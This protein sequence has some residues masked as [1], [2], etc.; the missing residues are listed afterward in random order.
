[1]LF[2]LFTGYILPISYF[3]GMKRTIAF[4]FA[5]LFTM[6]SC[7][8]TATKK[9]D[10]PKPGT[11]VAAESE[12]V[13]EDTLNHSIFAVQVIADSNVKSGVYM[14]KAAFGLNKS[15][16]LF[17]MPKGGETF[18]PILR[19]GNTPYSYIVGFNVPNDT[20][21][22]DYFLVSSDGNATKMQYVKSYSFE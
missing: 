13:V 19:K 18:K 2:A 22:H 9:N 7:G 16:G 21:F 12:P 20:T 17:T 14:V 15:H 11:I 1:M 10:V 6:N 4:A 5:A 8:D 3:C